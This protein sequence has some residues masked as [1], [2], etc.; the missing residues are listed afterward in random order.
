MGGLE[1]FTNF[2]CPL[3]GTIIC[4]VMY[5][6]PLAAVWKARETQTLGTLNPIPF[7]IA[8]MN[9]F[10]WVI[11][12]VQLGDY[13]IYI[14]NCPGVIFGMYFTVSSLALLASKEGGLKSNSF[15]MLEAIL[16]GGFVF[17][18]ILVMIIGITLSS[19]ADTGKLIIAFVANSTCII[20]YG[21]PCSTM[22]SV[23][24]SKDSSS[25]YPP[26]IVANALNA[27]LWC[28]Y[29]FFALGD[30]FV[31][32]PN[33]IGL[34]LSIIQLSLI[35]MYR[36]KAVKA[37]LIISTSVKSPLSS[38]RHSEKNDYLMDNNNF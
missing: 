38:S 22:L 6:S 1:V 2:V 8:V 24:S 23:I 28:V 32:V 20:Y 10:A 29:G 14:A 16:I 35:V 21:A 19:H 34:S 33:G 25:L 31:Y 18:G 5:T 9:A 37:E 15:R 12:G 26:M 36:P 4:C 17:F 13:F 30:I 3:L 7:G 27:T 11:Y